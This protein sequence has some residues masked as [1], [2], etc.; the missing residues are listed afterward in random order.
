MSALRAVTIDAAWQT[1]STHP[2]RCPGKY[3]DLAI[4]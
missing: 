4:L 1:H 3:A 2:G